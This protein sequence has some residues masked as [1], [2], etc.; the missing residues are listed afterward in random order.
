MLVA[1]FRRMLIFLP[2][3]LSVSQP[4]LF[5]LLTCFFFWLKNG[6]FR[7][8]TALMKSSPFLCC[9]SSVSQSVCSCLNQP[10]N[11]S[12]K[13]KQASK[14]WKKKVIIMVEWEQ[15]KKTD[16]ADASLISERWLMANDQR[17]RSSVATL[18]EIKKLQLTTLLWKAPE[19][20]STDD[21]VMTVSASQW[22]VGGSA[23]KDIKN[24][25]PLNQLLKRIIIMITIKFKTTTPLSLAHCFRPKQK[26]AIKV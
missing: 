16:A 1:K 12:E 20:K 17:R 13:G 18:I 24:L 26:Y 7:W 8:R 15:W 6:S 2:A 9:Q 19:N 4:S 10:I 23:E 22:R 14:E 5:F 3:T 21:V 25:G 11:Y